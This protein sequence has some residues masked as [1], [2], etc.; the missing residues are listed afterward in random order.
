[1]SD[2][3]RWE[4]RGPVRI[5]RTHFA[6]WNAEVGAWSPLANRAV[7]TFRPDGNVSDTEYHNP[8][9]SG[10][11]H[12]RVYG[13]RDRLTEDQWWANDA[14]TR[15]I[16][17]MY[18]V[19]GR[20]VSSKAIDTDGNQRETELC[21]YDDRG[22]RTKLVILPVAERNADNWRMI[23][24][25]MH[26]GVEGTDV[27]YSAPGAT[28]S[29]T[30]YDEHERPSEVSYLDA[31]DA[32]LC[33]VVFSRDDAGRLL[34]ERMEFSGL[35]RLL[36]PAIDANMPPDERAPLMELLK[37]AFSDQT[38]SVVTYAYDER[39]RR[40]ESVRRMGQ[41]SEE[42]LT[43]RYDDFDN[44]VEQVT[45]HLSREMRMDGGTLK[46]EDRPSHV[47]HVRFEYQYDAHR[48]WTERI[49]WQLMEPSTNERPLNVER[50]TIVYY[51]E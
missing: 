25:G 24:R 47:Q 19:Y 43:I 21:R 41:L 8:D 30:V 15:R 4:L 23:S 39:G 32:V 14:L 10:V 48:N 17:Y 49:A 5:L 22:R 46:S 35:G 18:D 7:V 42:R 51:T 12:V 16:L 50:R 40:I 27:A 31:N 9:G 45:A 26:Y 11:R 13:D 33:C 20:P 44:P 37:T 6:E 3:K 28:T 1:M 34:N 2:L 29:M 38:F 36:G